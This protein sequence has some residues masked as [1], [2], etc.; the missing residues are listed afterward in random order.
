MAIQNTLRRLH[1]NSDFSVL[2]QKQLLD[3]ANSVIN[4][5]THFI[6]TV[7]AISL[8]VGGIGIMDIMLVSVSERTREIGIRK[9]IGATNRQI[10]NQFLVEGL[11]LSVTGGLIGVLASL[12]IDLGLKL[13]TNW[14]PALAWPMIVI[15]V[16]FSVLIGVIFSII[17]AIKA[18]AKNPIEALRD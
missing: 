17:P 14:H 8:L 13:Y 16:V 18:A 3:V 15:A 12:A 4:T 7:A 9:A 10:L 1:G 5:A 6:S 11:V 2:Q